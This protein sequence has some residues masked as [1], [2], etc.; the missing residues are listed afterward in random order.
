MIT[1]RSFTCLLFSC[2]FS[3]SSLSH[4]LLHLTRSVHLSSTPPSASSTSL[5]SFDSLL[6][7][8][9][10]SSLSSLASRLVSGDRQA[11]SRSIT[12]IESSRYA[13]RPAASYLLTCVLE[14]AA[15]QRSSTWYNEINGGQRR[16]L[17]IGISGPPG[18]GT[19]INRSC[20]RSYI[21]S[22]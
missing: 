12:I 9:V 14:L 2:R 18:V 19:S 6:S 3:F 20:T 10:R 15:K 1:A 17:R 5:Y 4:S 16:H 7:S 13:D 11:L 8:T 21:H 22:F